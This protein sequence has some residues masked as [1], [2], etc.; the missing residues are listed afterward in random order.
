VA[1]CWALAYHDAGVFPGY[2]LPHPTACRTRA[3]TA[4]LPGFRAANLLRWRASAGRTYSPTARHGRTALPSTFLV[5]ACLNVNE[6]RLHSD[7]RANMYH[8]NRSAGT[9]CS[10]IRQTWFG[11]PLNNPYR[12]FTFALLVLIVSSI[13]PA[14]ARSALAILTGQ[15]GARTTVPPPAIPLQLGFLC[16]PGKT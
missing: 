1:G 5:L 4:Y 7:I 9:W 12:T 16:T 15:E 13:P 6:G 3:T 2:L 10:S 8:S 14:N 11:G